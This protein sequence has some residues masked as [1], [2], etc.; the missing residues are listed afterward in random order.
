LTL[1]SGGVA[2]AAI[3]IESDFEEDAS[4]IPEMLLLN[5][6]SDDTVIGISASGNAWFVQSALAFSKSRG[7]LTVI[8]QR[9]YAE[10]SLSFCDQVIPLRS[11]NEVVAGST[12]MKA[13]T[14]TKKM[15]NFISSA[16]MI[17]MGK[18]AGPYMVDMA[19]INNKLVDRA[20]SI[21]GILYNLDD[22][23]A[24]QSLRDAGMNL[25]QVIRKIQSEMKRK[26]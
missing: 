13:G 22:L 4:A 19:C 24:D 3:E 1:I 7:A 11:G 6:T 15:L 16:V 23:E 26:K 21:L 25:G 12:R 18:V 8:I 17:G 10:E 20:K 2:D 14:A 5:I 9:D